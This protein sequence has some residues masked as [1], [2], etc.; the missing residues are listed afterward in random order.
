MAIL[1]ILLPLA[2]SLFLAVAVYTLIQLFNAVLAEY[3]RAQSLKNIRGPPSS[4]WLFGT[5]ALY[6]IFEALTGMD[7]GNLLE[8][9]IPKEYGEVDNRW[10]QEF[11]PV[12]RIKA[13]FGRERLMVA[14]PLALQSILHSDDFISAPSR[15]A[16]L[17]WIF[18][19]MGQCGILALEGPRHR[20]LR[21]ALNIGFTTPAVRSYLPSFKTL[22]EALCESLEEKINKA[23][24]F[25]A[26]LVVD[27]CPYLNTATLGA[28]SEA[29][30]G[31]KVTDLSPDL[32]QTNSKVV[33]LSSTVSASQLLLDEVLNLNFLPNWLVALAGRF[34]IGQALMIARDE[35]KIST[36]DGTKIVNQK[37][38]AA[39]AGAESFDDMTDVYGKILHGEIL[40]NSAPEITIGDLIGQTSMMLIAGQ[41]TVAVALGWLFMALAKDQDI[42][43]QLRNEIATIGTE[44]M[45]DKYPLLNAVIKETLRLW[46]A[47]PLLFRLAAKDTTI[48][49][50]QPI[51]TT[52]GH[53]IDHIPILKGQLL[54]LS[55]YAYERDQ[56]R[57]GDDS[58]QFNPLRWL[59][60]QPRLRQEPSFGPYS[61]LIAFSSGAHHCLG[62]CFA[63]LEM[64]VI[65]CA[66]L[67][68]FKLHPANEVAHPMLATILMPTDGEGKKRAACGV[69]RLL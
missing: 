50:S 18:D 66:V 8:M 23:E 47:L 51:T 56:N 64:Q 68:K 46:P 24:S 14:D 60:D 48:P 55:P 36:M 3:R 6:A 33:T 2:A 39:K 4:S 22:A 57:W 35:N 17:T 34:P 7:T 37:V 16:F 40:G 21:A 31:W 25:N 26:P 19:I 12:Y 30:F 45:Y 28:I 1:A 13:G 63:I 54:T 53:K 5:A 41:D 44:D 67:R 49:L 38:E 59:R 10:L 27:L 29:A 42:Q 43:D 61:N 58:N 32:V 65:V 62:W 11:G 69:Q 20:T 15:Q 52:D 9:H